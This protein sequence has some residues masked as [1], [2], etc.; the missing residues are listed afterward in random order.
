MFKSTSITLEQPISDFVSKLVD[1]GR[2]NSS[3]DVIHCALSLLKHQE[4]RLTELKNAIILGD[5]S[6]ESSLSLHDIAAQVKKKHG[7]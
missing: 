2:Y 4:H 7:L 5:Q 3:S 1:S 6:G